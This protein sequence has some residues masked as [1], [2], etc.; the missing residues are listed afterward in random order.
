MNTATRLLGT[1]LILPALVLVHPTSAAAAEPAVTSA[2]VSSGTLTVSW[3]LPAGLCSDSVRYGDDVSSSGLVFPFYYQS[4]FFNLPCEATSASSGV[5]SGTY[6]VQV[7]LCQGPCRDGSPRV[8][9]GAVRS[10]SP[11]EPVPTE[12]NPPVSE[13]PAEPL[14]PLKVDFD[15]VMPRRNY[16]GGCPDFTKHPEA[17]APRRWLVYLHVTT[18]GSDLCDPEV[19]Y[20]WQVHPAVTIARVTRLPRDIGVYGDCYFV[21][22]FP[23]EGSYDVTLRAAAEGRESDVKTKEVVVQDWLIVAIGDSVAS[24]EGNPLA[25]FDVL[26]GKWNDTRCH[27]SNS[28][29]GAVAAAKLEDHDDHTSVTLLHL[30]CS[31]AQVFSG[32]IGPYAGLIPPRHSPPLRPQI[33]EARR[34]V[35]GREIDAVLVSIGANDIGFGDIVSFCFMEPRCFLQKPEGSAVSLDAVTKAKLAGLPDHYGALAPRL[36]TLTSP[37]RVYIAEYF[38]PTTNASGD[39]CTQM[40]GLLPNQQWKAIEK[41]EVEW[42][43]RAVVVKLNEGVGAATRR[44]GWRLVGGIQDGFRGHGYCAGTRRWIVQLH[45]SLLDQRDRYG[46]MHPNFL[47]HEFIGGRVAAALVRDFYRR[48]G[49]RCPAPCRPA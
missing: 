23:K 22:A 48:G 13:P 2:V 25:G 45:D 30:A 41:A 1:A 42:A 21:G 36:R 32:L 40:L 38:D 17:I 39:P 3:T 4:S 7:S 10:T 14:E 24:G 18:D 27:R 49:P 44:W 12:P 35:N 5:A 19:T 11:S 28:A 16:C 15:W 6:W 26:P 46:T 37:D 9:T 33:D 8:Y 29:Y 43:H 20:R 47:G 34:L 31:G